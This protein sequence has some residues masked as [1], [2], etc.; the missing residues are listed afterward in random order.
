MISLIII[1]YNNSG[2]VPKLVSSLANGLEGPTEL[3]FLDNASS[4]NTFTQLKN[5]LA[6]SKSKDKIKVIR[7]RKNAGFTK[8]LNKCVRQSSSDTVLILNPDVYVYK[9]VVKKLLK[10]YKTRKN[11]I[12][13][14]QLIDY[15]NEIQDS[16]VK[17]CDFKDCLFEMTNLKK[18]FKKSNFWIEKKN[19]IQEVK[20]VSG[21]FMLLSKK[22]IEDVGYFDEK[23]W[24]YLE[25]LDFCIRARKKNYKIYYFPEAKI[26]HFGGGSSKN[27]I[28]INETEWLKSR[29]VFFKKHFPPFQY[30]IFKLIETMEL[31]VLKINK[32]LKSDRIE[33]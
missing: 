31:P 28:K 19:N 11:S 22:T 21:G 7:N 15:K 4:D 14:G 8:A 10:F 1:F 29:R 17:S 9:D 27:R 18:L 2:F 3:I 6:D 16:A 30:F 26:R 24:L 23:F 20:A 32:L 13:G 5:S 25:D 12:V 33:K